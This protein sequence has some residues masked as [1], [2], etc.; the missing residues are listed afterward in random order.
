M[1]EI[2][3]PKVVRATLSDEQIRELAR[4]VGKDGAQHYA[5]K[6]GVKI[7]LIRSAI[8]SLRKAGVKI[9]LPPR[10]GAHGRYKVIAEQ[11]NAGAPK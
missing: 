11:L 6:F 1:A 9:V 3:K 5:K 2:K 10:K 4:G 7:G 8:A